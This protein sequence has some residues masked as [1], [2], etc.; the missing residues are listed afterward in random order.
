MKARSKVTGAGSRR[1]KAKTSE[2]VPDLTETMRVPRKWQTYY[3]RLIGLRDHLLHTRSDLKSDAR[4][5]SPSYSLH[6]ADAATDNFD[7]DFALSMLSS[8]QDAIYEIEQALKRIRDGTYG[9]CETTGK[10]IDERRL[11]AIPWTRFSAEAER[12]LERTGGAPHAKLGEVKR[13]VKE[14]TEESSN[15]TE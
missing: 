6:M 15:D 12:E 13:V 1:P 11:E 2:I 10:R 3:N 9:I 14:S 5:T 4:N 7:R 8:E